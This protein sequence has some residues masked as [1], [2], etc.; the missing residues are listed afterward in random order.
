V[1]KTRAL[2]EP[3]KYAVCSPADMPIKNFYK[4]FFDEVFIFFH[5]FIK[6]LTIDI[7]SFFSDSYPCKNDVISTCELVTW[8]AFTEKSGIAGFHQLD[9]GLRTLILG[10]KKEFANETLAKLIKDTCEQ[11][12]LVYPTEGCFLELLTNTFLEAVKN[13][14]YD[15]LWVGDEFCTER[16]L[17]FIDDLIKENNPFGV[18]HINLFTH[19]NRIL[20]TTHWDSHFSMKCSD[21]NTIDR[22][23][24]FGSLEGFYCNDKTEI[25]WSLQ[26]E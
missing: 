13:E 1:N 5:P 21:R 11:M 18:Q 26:N 24:G 6:P 2:P 12:N 16:K 19:D 22:I 17:M 20:I 14:G 7:K 15:W 25:Y 9:I 10:L 3:H 23:V 8:T 4:G